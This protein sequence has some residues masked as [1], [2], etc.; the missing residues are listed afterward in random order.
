MNINITPLNVLNALMS[1]AAIG[2]GLNPL[3]LGPHGA[4]IVGVCVLALNVGHSLLSKP[5]SAPTAIPKAL[6][7]VLMLI[8]VVSL[9]APLT[10]CKTTPTATQQADIAVAI[11]VAV[12]ASVQAHSADP[13]VW[14]DRAQAYETIAKTL[15]ATNDAGTGATLA[16]LRADLQPLI[17][18]LGPADALAANALVAGLVPYIQAQI[19]ANPNNGTLQTNLSLIL[20]DVIAACAAYTGS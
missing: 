18:K 10:A 6:L 13:A 15:K 16:T 17:A 14:K 11:D 4:V 2:A 19:D 5:A 8:L 12:A 1:V 20:A 7:A 9:C 3:L